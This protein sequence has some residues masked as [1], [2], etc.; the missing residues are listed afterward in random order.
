M[1]VM[2]AMLLCLLL[3][4][5]MTTKVSF[6]DDSSLNSAEVS[7]AST[8]QV[9]DICEKDILNW[10]PEDYTLLL[11]TPREMLYEIGGIDDPWAERDPNIGL[12]VMQVP[13]MR[14]YYTYDF[15]QSTIGFDRYFDAEAAAKDN[16]A[17][18]CMS[19]FNMTA[20]DVV[21]QYEKIDITEY[22]Y[23]DFTP[24]GG[25][26]RCIYYMAYHT[27]GLIYVFDLRY[28]G[29]PI[30]VEEQQS[31]EVVFIYTILEENSQM[32]R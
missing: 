7:D 30:A 20:K 24:A 10:T 16:P 27:D 8:E 17:F 18:I 26:K 4:A 14:R 11:T 1:K 23:E 29:A 12:G 2:S 31:L 25:T 32:L 9:K 5:C 28:D 21:A 13:F 19:P 3:C 22:A 6:I 15:G